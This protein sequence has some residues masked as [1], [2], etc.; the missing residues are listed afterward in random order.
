ME[1]DSEAEKVTDP[2]ADQSVISVFH[3]VDMINSSIMV[4]WLAHRMLVMMH[5]Y[6]VEELF[7]NCFKVEKCFT[8]L[9]DP[10]LCRLLRDQ[11]LVKT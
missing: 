9:Y 6:I 7:F 5:D 1:F 11:L 2:P 3:N 8:E 10:F 4:W